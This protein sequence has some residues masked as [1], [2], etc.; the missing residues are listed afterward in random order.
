MST[1]PTLNRL[2]PRVLTIAGSDSGGSAGLQADLKTL[3]AHD[4]FGMS[5]VTLVTAQDTRR[6]HHA[7]PMPEPLIAQQ[8]DVV[9]ADIGADAV[10]TGLLARASVVRLVADRLAAHQVRQV[11]VDPVL[12]DGQRCPFV[13]ADT[14]TAYRETLFPQATI[15]TPNID[16]AALLLDMPIRTVADQH[17]AVKRLHTLGPRYVFLKGGHLPQDG[18]IRNL[19]F[20]GQQITYLCAPLLPLDNPHGVGCTLA[21]ALAANLA[22]GLAP[23]AAARAAHDYLQAGLHSSLTRQIGKGRQPVHHAHAAFQNGNPKPKS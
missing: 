14:L 21:A 10:K 15:I 3:E 16:E 22:Q 18:E 23:Q 8:I 9:L 19:W 1:H 13:D 5:V 4:I 7:L 20:D 2:P 11:V 17:E 12:V 6:V